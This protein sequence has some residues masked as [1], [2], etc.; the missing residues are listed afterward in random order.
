MQN[1]A[2][3]SSYRLPTKSRPLT[4]LSCERARRA[5]D[6]RFDGRFFTAVKTTGIYCRPIC[7]A[8]PPLE[9]N[10]EYYPSAITAA[11]AGF[12]PCLRCRPDSAPDS[13]AWLG[14]QT[15]FLRA[16][17]LIHQGELQSG[18]IASLASRLGISDRYLR[19]LFQQ[20][21][22]TSPKKYGIYRQ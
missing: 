11:Q 9:K 7:P 21:I 22:G 17:E 4:R 5:R 16:V 8:N 18:S 13:W 15:T 20:N 2:D 10:V 1:N 14:A 6:A 3:Q 19:E 12:R